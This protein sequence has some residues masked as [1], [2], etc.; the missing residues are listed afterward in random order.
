MVFFKRLKIKRIV[1]KLKSLQHTRTTTQASDEAI[2]KEINLYHNLATLMLT[3]R[4]KIKKFP[5]ARVS[6]LESYR[7]AAALND[8]T[9]QYILGKAL[10]NEA[11]HRYQLQ[12]EVFASNSNLKTMTQLFEEAHAYLKAAETSGHIQAKR[13]RGL[14]Y[15]NGWGVD[16]DQKYGFELI[17][18]SID[19]EKSWDKVPQIFAA[20][21]LNK[22]E[23]FSRLSE[24]RQNNH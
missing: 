3:L 7:A 13:L 6:A 23:F 21:G 14:C 9:A 1:K 18:A 17:V 2:K 15:V 5:Y 11:K 19:Q 8:V 24:V 12:Q 16:K 10:L 22:P 4:K 20:M